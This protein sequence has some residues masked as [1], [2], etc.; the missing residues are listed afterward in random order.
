MVR[1]EWSGEALTRSGR[2]PVFAALV[3]AGT[4]APALSQFVLPPSQNR[5]RPIT[6]DLA[7]DERFFRVP[8]PRARPRIPLPRPAP[9]GAKI[10]GP[11]N[12]RGH[13]AV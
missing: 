7:P 1:L 5:D 12:L 10:A 6:G 13:Y 11:R 8:L 3:L 4:G 2:T 9:V